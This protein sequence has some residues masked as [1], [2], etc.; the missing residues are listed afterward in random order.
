MLPVSGDPRASA[1]EWSESV[2]A[3]VPGADVSMRNAWQRLTETADRHDDPG[4][5]TALIGWEWSSTPGGA[6]LHRVVLT[7]ADGETARRFLPF[8]SGDS[9]YPEDL[10]AWLERTGDET[11]A[12]FLAIP[13]NSNISKGLMFAERTL[14]GEPIDAEHARRR[15]A[16]ERMV[17]VTQIKG[18]SETHPELSPDD[19]FADFEPYTDYI[20]QQGEPYRAGRGDYVRAG[21]RTGL[22]LE[23]RTGTNPFRFGMLG[24]T[25]AH[26]GLSSAEEPNFWGK[27]AVDSIPENKSG[28]VLLG[29]SGWRMS[30]SGLAAV[31]AERND[32]GAI[33]DALQRREAYASTGPR[34]RVRVFAAPGLDETALDEPA[35]ALQR[36]AV[37]MGGILSAD[38]SDRP[39]ALVIRAAR[40]PAA[41]SL[42]R[43]QVV[44]GWVDAAGESHEQVFDAAWAGDRVPDANGRVPKLASSVDLTDGSHD[45]AT[46]AAELATVWRDPQFDPEQAAFYYVRVLQIP[47]ARHSLFDAIALGM[48][49]PDTGP[50][51]I[52]ERAYTSPI[53]YRP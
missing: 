42:D 9:P 44:K 7:D 10:W 14:R 24:S 52:R 18:D 1:A 13:H 33:V 35:G 28:S 3:G 34:I 4:N 26:T 38:D 22:E 19:P 15:M 30:A 17:E 46:G 48:E 32:R 20:Q 6:N 21:L 12:R 37:P 11:G 16:F 5:F 50:A 36:R 25:D 51:V 43:I 31:W 45:D 47:T 8:S 40:D 53:W 39:P 49:R 41:A 29:A 27:M 23:A 2:A